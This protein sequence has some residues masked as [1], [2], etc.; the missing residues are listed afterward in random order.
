MFLKCEHSDHIEYKYM[1]EIVNVNECGIN[2]F[3]RKHASLSRLSMMSTPSRIEA[4]VLC[5]EHYNM[6][7]IP[8]ASGA[9]CVLCQGAQTNSIKDTVPFHLNYL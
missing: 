4:I 6:I 9:C 8:P 1:H 3:V 5:L 2:I 7:M